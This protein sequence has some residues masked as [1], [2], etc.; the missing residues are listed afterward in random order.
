ML[1]AAVGKACERQRHVQHQR[2]HA[3]ALGWTE[4]QV[5][6]W[7][8]HSCPVVLPW[9]HWC[10]IGNVLGLY[11]LIPLSSFQISIFSS[12]RDNWLDKLVM[13]QGSYTLCKSSFIAVLR[14]LYLVYNFFEK[15]FLFKV[16]KFLQ[17]KILKM[18]INM[19]VLTW[20][21][22]KSVH[23]GN[24]TLFIFWWY[25]KVGHFL[26]VLVYITNTVARQIFPLPILWALTDMFFLFWRYR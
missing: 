20:T 21:V 15:L 10:D 13:A 5:A 6:L 11:R 9:W 23:E 3:Q 7:L 8:W 19:F 17:F 14:I 2:G 24:V 18:S 4:E 16:K 25:S 1:E 12:A 22:Y 26:S